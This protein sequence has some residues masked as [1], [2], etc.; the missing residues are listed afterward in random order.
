MSD[1]IQAI[2]LPNND[3]ELVPSLPCPF[4]VCDAVRGGRPWQFSHLD[5]C[6]KCGSRA[7]VTAPDEVSIKALIDKHLL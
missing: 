3:K 2:D 6:E 5:S 4:L 1:T 7:A